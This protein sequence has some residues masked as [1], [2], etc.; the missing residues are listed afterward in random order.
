MLIY[1]GREELEVRPDVADYVLGSCLGLV[2]KS[3]EGFDHNALVSC[4][5]YSYSTNS[6]ITWCACPCVLLAVL[7]F[8]AAFPPHWTHVAV[9]HA[10]TA[11]CMGLQIADYL[12]NPQL[13]TIANKD[14]SFLQQFYAGN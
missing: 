3:V 12:T 5:W 8:A 10:L 14:S 6:G 9:A 7:V 13:S 11:M 4:R 1:K 2:C